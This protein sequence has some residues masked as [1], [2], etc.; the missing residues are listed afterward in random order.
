MKI[1]NYDKETFILRLEKIRDVL[2]KH[3]LESLLLIN[4]S[5]GLNNEANGILLNWLFKGIA[6]I[7]TLNS[8]Y[9]NSVYEETFFLIN[10]ENIEC[11]LPQV[12]YDELFDLIKLSNC[13]TADIFSIEKA[14]EDRKSFE[15]EKMANFVKFVHNKTNFGVVMDNREIKEKISD[16]EKWPLC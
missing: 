9:L 14:D 5:D 8:F 1:P 4:G 6:G 13:V 7:S 15:R 16:I 3:N 10:R 12:L 2:R 11:F